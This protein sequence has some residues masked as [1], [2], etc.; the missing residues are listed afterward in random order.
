MAG[1]FR[2]N[3]VRPVFATGAAMNIGLELSIAMF[4]FRRASIFK[5]GSYMAGD[6]NSLE[7]EIAVLDDPE[8]ILECVKEWSGYGIG[9]IISDK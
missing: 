4:N 5:R 6:M 3:V 2:R 8:K 7:S 9:V 1:G